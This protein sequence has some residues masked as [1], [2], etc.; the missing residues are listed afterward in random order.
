[1]DDEADSAKKPD[2]MAIGGDGG[3][4]VDKPK[5]TIEK[6]FALVVMPD[7]ITVPLPCPELPTIVLDAITAIQVGHCLHAGLIPA[8]ALVAQH[9]MNA[10]RSAQHHRELCSG[11]CCSRILFQFHPECS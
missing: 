4:Q 11:M 9:A 6:E 8:A 2:K 7:R 10:C 1:M 5:H 3:F